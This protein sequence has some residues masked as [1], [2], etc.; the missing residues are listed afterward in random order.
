MQEGHHCDRH[1]ER[2]DDK[3]KVPRRELQRDALKVVD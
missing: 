2:K 1:Q 3:E